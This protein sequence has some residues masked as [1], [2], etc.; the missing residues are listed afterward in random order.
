MNPFGFNF[1]NTFE[2]LP[3][4]FYRKSGTTPVDFPEIVA[5]NSSLAVEL[6]LDE[7]KLQTDEGKEVVAR[8]RRPEGVS[9]ISQAYAG[10]QFGNLSMLGD[11]RAVLIGEQVTPAGNRFDL[12]LRGSGR[13]VFSRSGDGRAPTGPMLRE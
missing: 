11:G 6:G 1:D 12:Q 5:F 7:E 9:P 13:T 4:S 2:L 10:D 8:N 3:D